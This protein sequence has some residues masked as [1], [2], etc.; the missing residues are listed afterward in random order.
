MDLR[1][2]IDTTQIIHEATTEAK[3]LIQKR[4]KQNALDH[5]RPYTTMKGRWEE[6][7]MK[8]KARKHLFQ[9]TSPIDKER[10]NAP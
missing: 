10:E 6:S 5:I 2:D 8:S 4:M 9:P 1:L 7:E 3:Q